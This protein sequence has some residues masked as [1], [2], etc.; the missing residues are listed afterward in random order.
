[1]DTLEFSTSG[2]RWRVDTATLRRPCDHDG[3]RRAAAAILRGRA[4]AVAEPLRAGAFTGD[5]ASGASC[6]CG[7][8]TLSPHCHGTHTEC[9]GH[10]TGDAT[11]V[12]ALTPVPPALAALVTVRPGPLG[13]ERRTTGRD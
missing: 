8:Y 13:L 5:V 4:G 7:V 9:V 11:H 12:A 2:R 6:N 3:V 10:L 1:M